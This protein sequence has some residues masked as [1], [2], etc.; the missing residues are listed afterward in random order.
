[1]RESNI[2]EICMRDKRTSASRLIGNHCVIN[3]LKIENMKGKEHESKLRVI[4]KCVCKIVQTC[5]KVF[6]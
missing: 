2:S 1:M 5:D 3:G 6:D 4:V